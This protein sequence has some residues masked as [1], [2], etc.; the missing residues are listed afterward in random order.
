MTLKPWPFQVDAIDLFSRLP[1]GYLADECGLGKTIVAIEV[2]KHRRLHDTRAA[3]QGPCLI[4]C[5]KSVK[6]QWLDEIDRWDPEANV[7][8]TGIAG[9]MPN[10]ESGQLFKLDWLFKPTRRNAYVIM[11]YEGVIRQAT[12]LAKYYWSS[13]ICDEVH[14]IKNRKAKRT[15]YIK[16][17]QTSHRLGLS[18][19]PL[20]KNPGELWSVLHWLYPEEFRSYWKFFERFVEYRKHPYLG[21]RE[22]LGPKNE[23]ELGKLIGSFFLRRTKQEVLP[24]LP[25]RIDTYVTVPMLRQ[26]QA[27]YDKIRKAK[28]IEVHL[29]SVP[30]T[31]RSPSSPALI[32]E[33]SQHT[34]QSAALLIPNTLAK[35]TRL[36]QVLSDPFQKPFNQRIPSAKL[37]WVRDYVK[38]NPGIPM[39]IFSK[40]RAPIM[41]LA[42]ELGA[43]LHVGGNS[44]YEEFKYGKRTLLCGTID[45]LG[46]SLDLGRASRAIF[47]DQHWSTQ[48][49]QQ[50][51]DRIHR[52]TATEPK[53]VLVLVTPNSVDTLVQKSLD[54]G[55]STQTLVFNAIKEWEVT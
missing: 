50:A 24:D 40:F 51:F 11:H 25:P 31:P 44:N 55:W 12:E 54:Q 43:A 45:A 37:E 14:R 1:G 26:Q 8:M 38:D 6:S 19:T 28:D 34:G 18:G 21:Y 30:P 7:V 3:S 47:I 13:I 17:L 9:A 42:E 49:M 36:Q 33:S 10:W 52:A 41:R 48:K 32:A 39:L 22:I 27:L 35:I 53:H 15:Q 46:E 5:P 29:D 4:V 2:V 20:H 23:K 16:L